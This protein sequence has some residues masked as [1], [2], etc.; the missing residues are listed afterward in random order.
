MKRGALIAIS[1]LAVPLLAALL[2]LAA[3]SAGE[4]PRSPQEIYETRCA[5]CHDAGGW[6]TRTLAKRVPEGQAVLTA[7]TN[8]PA[9]YTAF[10]VRRGIGSMPQFNPSELT[11][12][13]LEAL[14]E[15]LQ[16][17]D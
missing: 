2:P 6:G 10:V 16:G 13:E 4:E 5:Y 1:A 9:A 14:A 12:E 3:R 7:R 11:D 8:L 15:W 17:G